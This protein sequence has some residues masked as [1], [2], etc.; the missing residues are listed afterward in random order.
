M[1]SFHDLISL[2]K[3]LFI[4]KIEIWFPST[5][6]VSLKPGKKKSHDFTFTGKTFEYNSY[7]AVAIHIF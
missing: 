6:V 1:L 2:F 7:H 4:S 3:H 5:F